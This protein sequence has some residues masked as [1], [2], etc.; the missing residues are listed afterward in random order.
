MMSRYSIARTPPCLLLAAVLLITASACTRTPKIKYY[1][2]TPAGA[3]TALLQQ[4]R[5]AAAVIGIGPVRLREH[6]DSSRLVTRIEANSVEMAEYHRWAEQPAANISWVL[7][8]NLASL[9]DTE[10]I[11]V[12]PWD[13]ATAVDFQ[14]EME[15]LHLEGTAGNQARF[16]VLWQIL[17]ADGDRLLDR[18]RSSYRVAAASQEPDTLAAALS[19]AL[20]RLSIDVAEALAGLAA[21]R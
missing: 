17:G 3:E 18:R 7:R 21:E 1:R 13:G 6:L 12:F 2:L 4:T 5:T 15:V 9:L 10:H 14:L 8:D 16:D 19:E 20:W 11:A